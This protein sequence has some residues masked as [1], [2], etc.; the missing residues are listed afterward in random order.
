M[1]LK[2]KTQ[3]RGVRAFTLIELLVVVAIIAVL[4]AILLPVLSQAREQAKQ[5]VCLANQRTLALSFAQYANEYRDAIVSSFTDATGWVDW[6]KREDGGY[7][8]NNQIRRQTD[9]NAEWRG[10]R[11]GRLFPYTR[12]VEVY[13]CP[14]DRRNT[15]S[16]EFGAL[17][18][19]TYS[20]PN[21]LSGD[22]GWES[23]I[24]G[25]RVSARVTQLRRPADSFAFVEESDPRGINMGSWV[26][27]LNKQEWID[28]LTVWHYDKGTIGFSDGHA[29]V[30]AWVDRRT[31]IMSRDQQFYLD[32][33]NNADHE[34]LRTR[35]WVDP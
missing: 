34:Y 31:I 6:P 26:M 7:L 25:T 4:M 27:Y 3:R 19:R 13:R 16:R 32:A 1:R 30:H 9:S 10:I 18:Y 15:L 14:S 33:S 29:I 8:N 22:A 35:W 17:A 12:Q 28:P 5:T 24:G 11:D 20:M 23:S 2:V 21:Y